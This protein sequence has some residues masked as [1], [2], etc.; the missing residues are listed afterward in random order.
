MTALQIVSFLMLIFGGMS[1]QQSVI[2]I[3]SNP[4]MT[5]FDMR[6]AAMIGIMGILFVVIGVSGLGDS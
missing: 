5:R 6:V 1:I 2:W 3:V 4:R